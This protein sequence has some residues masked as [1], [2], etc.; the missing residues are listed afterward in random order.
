M[1]PD[2]TV[3]AIEEL[4]KALHELEFV[5]FQQRHSDVLDGL[6]GRALTTTDSKELA[7]SARMLARTNRTEIIPALERGRRSGTSLE[8]RDMTKAL[9]QLRTEQAN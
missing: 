5:Q 6:V 3:F 4:E 1:N 8:R 7:Y 9:K 2:N